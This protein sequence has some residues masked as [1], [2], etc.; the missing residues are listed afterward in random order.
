MFYLQ[1][2]SEKWLKLPRKIRFFIIGCLNAAVSYGFYILFCLILGMTKYQTALVFSWLFSSV[3]SFSVQRNLVFQSCGNPFKEYAKCCVS[4]SVS[5]F[6]NAI[7][8]EITNKLLKM[9]VFVGQIVS[10]LAVAVCTYILFRNFAFK[11]VS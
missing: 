1:N 5:Y 4:W 6:F 7:L 2:V 8:L 11:K 3:I 9:N 10:T